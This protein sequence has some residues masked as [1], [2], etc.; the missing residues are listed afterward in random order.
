[1]GWHLARDREFAEQAL[2]RS[3]DYFRTLIEN[4]SDII[5]ILNTKGKILFQSPS[6]ERVLGYRADEMLDKNAF[7]LIHPNDVQRLLA[8][9]SGDLINPNLQAPIEYRFRHRDGT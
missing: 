7:D 6:I 8:V 4:S 9:F 2:R 1:M 5:T 3:E